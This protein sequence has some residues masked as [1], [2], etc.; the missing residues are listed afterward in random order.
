MDS[1]FLP[2][3]TDS[4]MTSSSAHLSFVLACARVTSCKAAVR[5]PWGLKKPVNQ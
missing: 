1:S 5:K 3:Q 4:M 2:V